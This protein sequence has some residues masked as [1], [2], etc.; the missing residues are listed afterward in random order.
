MP[1]VEDVDGIR[2]NSKINC[3]SIPHDWDAAYTLFVGLVSP[4]WILPDQ[5][6]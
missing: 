5:L 4:A 1:D 3:V 2:H 6:R